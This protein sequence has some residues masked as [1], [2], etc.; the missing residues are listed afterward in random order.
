VT[1]PQ[2]LGPTIIS[3]KNKPVRIV[4]HNLLPTGAG[5]DLFMPV[6]TTLMGS[7]M[8]GGWDEYDPFP[9]AG[10]TVMD[11]VRNPPC[12]WLGWPGRT[13]DGRARLLHQ[14]PPDAA[15]ARRQHAV[16]QRRH[17][18]PVDLTPAG[19][20]TDYPQGVSVG[21]VPDMNVCTG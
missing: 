13:Q 10:G 5:G 9:V 14:E 21:N 12:T 2:W 18:A 16:D 3:N 6:D 7:G 1:S 19:E 17:A 8:A 11:A 15:P 20:N 4:F